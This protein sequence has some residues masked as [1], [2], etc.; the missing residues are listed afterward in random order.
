MDS[1]N[2]LLDRDHYMISQAVKLPVIATV[3]EIERG[4]DDI[5]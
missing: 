1:A 3:T 4:S 2:G 5:L